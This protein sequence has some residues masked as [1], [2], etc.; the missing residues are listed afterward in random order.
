[1]RRIAAACL[2][3]SGFLV[4]AGCARETPS[5]ADG[6]P[7]SRIA[8]IEQ[9]A[10]DGR[11][12]DLPRIVEN[13][14]SDDA[15]VRMAAIAALRRMTGE[16]LGYRFDDPPAERQAAVERWAG[17]IRAHP[18]QASARPAAPLP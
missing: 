17:W 15:S 3:L 7:A 9:S 16:T 8:A 6:S 2:A 11:V 5:Y 13:L 18:P 14:S 1:M 12:A 10:S 4:P